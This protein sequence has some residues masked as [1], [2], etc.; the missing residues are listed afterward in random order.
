MDVKKALK[1]ALRL[2]KEV[3]LLLG[4]TLALVERLVELFR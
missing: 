2:W 4:A 1:E 3:V